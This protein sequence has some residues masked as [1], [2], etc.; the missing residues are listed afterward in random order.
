MSAT[1]NNKDK[2]QGTP[3]QQNQPGRGIQNQQGQKQNQ[4]PKFHTGDRVHWEP[5]QK[6]VSTSSD[7]ERKPGAQNQQGNFQQGQSRFQGDQGKM[8]NQ[9]RDINKDDASK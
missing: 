3:G 8:K 4:E 7:K 1:D 5:G 2:S 9:N 6:Q